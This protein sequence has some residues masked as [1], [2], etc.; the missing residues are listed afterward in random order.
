MIKTGPF[1]S[2]APTTAGAALRLFLFALLALGV[3]AQ[4]ASAKDDD[5]TG[6]ARIK[7]E[8]HRLQQSLAQKPVNIP[9]M[10]RLASMIGDSLNG[11][12]TELAHGHVFASLEKLG[13]ATDL[14]YGARSV[15]ERTETVKQGLPAFET[16]WGKVSQEVTALGQKARSQSAK[17]SPAAIRALS[18]TALGK[19]TPLLDGGRG[20]ATATSPR[21]GLLYVGQAEGEA[22]FAAFLDKLDLPGTSASFPFRSLL[23]ELQAL[24]EKTNAAF[25]PPRSIEMHPRFIAL[26]SA[27]KFARELDSSKAYA[28]ALYQ[29][30]EAVRHFGMLDAAVPDAA[31]Q[32]ELRRTITKELA[33][34]ADPKRDDSVARLFLERASSQIN[35]QGE[36]APSD[37]EWKAAQVIL[38]QVL[39]AY[40]GTLKPAAASLPR[41]G[42]T[43]TLTLVRW[44]YT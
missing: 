39:P 29:Y 28:G 3:S 14:L 9:E 2:R 32:A 12:D 24:Q 15:E 22:Q 20:F 18:E 33:K 27:L 34:I 1:T 10:S 44:P 41:A 13:Q 7:A 37:D 11:A 19:T 42:R 35:Q 8:I 26:N 6:T 36:A 17:N 23:P 38:G 21:D 31:K 4:S 43:A 5:S 30:L 25:Q 40:Y 16:I